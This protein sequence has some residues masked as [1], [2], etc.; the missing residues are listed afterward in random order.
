MPA[1]PY[2]TILCADWAKPLSGRA[3]YCCDV[4]TR[5]VERV[6]PPKDGWN[7]TEVVEAGLRRRANGPVLVGFDAPIGVS[8]SYLQAAITR[9]PEWSSHKGFIDWLM[10]ASQVTEFFNETNECDL[11]SVQRPFFAIPKSG[12]NRWEERLRCIDVDPL[13]RIDR[14]TRANPV[15]VVSG[16]AGSVGSAARD[17]WQ[18]LVP[19]L[20][21]EGRKISVW[22]FQ[23]S[24][25]ALASGPGVVIG[26]IYPKAV[27]A[28]ALSTELPERRSLLPLAK[29]RCSVRRKRID[30]LVASPWVAEH[31][32]RVDG[33]DAALDS[34]DAFDAL[35]ATAAL[36]RCV[37]EETPLARPETDDPVVEGGI[38]GCGSVSLEP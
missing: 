26:E 9:V 19:L 31:R 8:G 27:Y 11:W 14:L 1:P 37:L 18:G 2:R 33:L 22:P 13:R 25:E 32:V 28:I 3:V 35:M 5:T 30:E 36:L 29:R 23:G 12:R 21:D 24:L 4:A 38:L 15:F 16:I 7:V 20:K 17:I 10:A 6:A 34:Q